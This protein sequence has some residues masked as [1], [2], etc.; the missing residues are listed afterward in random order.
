M[1]F[2]SVTY[3]VFQMSDEE[4]CFKYSKDY[5]YDN[6]NFNGLE[7]FFVEVG[8]SVPY[9]ESNVTVCRDT[10]LKAKVDKTKS[11]LCM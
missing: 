2:R 1:L 9:L 10:T 5:S 8:C 3:E 4:K 7:K 6:C 11:R